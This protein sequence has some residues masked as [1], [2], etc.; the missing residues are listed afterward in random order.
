[1][2]AAAR[3]EYPDNR[4]LPASLAGSKRNATGGQ[5]I[6][7]GR[8][9]PAVPQQLVVLAVTVRFAE[10]ERKMRALQAGTND[11]RRLYGAPSTDDKDMTCDK[12]RLGFCMLNLESTFR[13]GL[14]HSNHVTFACSVN[15]LSRDAKVG[16]PAVCQV[17][18]DT[19]D[20]HSEDKTTV[21]VHGVQTIIDTGDQTISPGDQLYMDLNPF[22]TKQDGQDVPGVIIPGVSRTTLH[23]QV[24]PA[25]SSTRYALSRTLNDR[26]RLQ[27]GEIKDL[28]AIL[29]TGDALELLRVIR[30]FVQ[31]ACDD[32]KL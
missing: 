2:S 21:V 4:P 14:G 24:R 16:V 5:I 25:R 29:N 20:P 22:T 30:V 27:L 1:M 32:E 31:Y 11:P 28:E 9:D 23:P 12:G 17:S 6:S 3:E 7:P 13:P 19:T 8:F 15:G 10:Q 26:V 18:R